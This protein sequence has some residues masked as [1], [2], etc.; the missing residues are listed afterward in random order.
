[1][2]FA[3]RP[4]NS[5]GVHIVSGRMNSEELICSCACANL[6]KMPRNKLAG[7]LYDDTNICFGFHI[8]ASVVF[9][10]RHS[11]FHLTGRNVFQRESIDPMADLITNN[12]ISEFVDFRPR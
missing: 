1:M 10:R 6:Q 8:A 2:G 12:F 4:C 7:N 11:F 5:S 3:L 9:C